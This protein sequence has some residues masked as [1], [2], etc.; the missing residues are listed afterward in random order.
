MAMEVDSKNSK[1][2]KSI[3]ACIGC[4]LFMTIYI[5]THGARLPD[6]SKI[7]PQAMKAELI[8]K[9]GSDKENE[10]FFNAVAFAIDRKGRIFILDTGNSRIQCFSPE[11]KFLF[12]FG[13]YGQGPGELSKEAQ[14]IKILTDGQIYII[15]N[16][17]KKINIYDSEGK[18]LKSIKIS[19]Y[20]DDILLINDH[21]YLSSTLIEENFKPIHILDRS[22]RLV[23]TFG[24][25]IEPEIGLIKRV[26]RLPNPEPWKRLLRGCNFSNLALTSEGNII[27]SQDFPYHL[28]KYDTEGRIIKDIMAETDF[29]SYGHFKFTDEYAGIRVS[30]PEMARVLDVT[31]RDDEI[32]VP[33][34]NPNKDIFFIDV[35]NQELNL[36]ATYRM[37]NDLTSSKRQEYL[38]QVHI[39][40]DNNL[41]AMVISRE[42]PTYLGKYRLKMGTGKE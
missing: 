22:G 21:Y 38:G 2:F 37:P 39:D 15:D 33:Y 4:A 36:I 34:L 1:L 11:G 13:K 42:N 5:P 25:F 9:I 24:V 18:F 26:A 20:Y 30:S 40:N 16:W 32:L 28:I 19:I 10:D 3:F 6:K 17:L 35:Y 12:T 23:S 7:R 27:F 29:D 41:Y 31:V 8:M 14:K